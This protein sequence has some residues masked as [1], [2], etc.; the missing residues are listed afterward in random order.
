MDLKTGV[1]N[2][3]PNTLLDYSSHDQFS[4]SLFKYKFYFDFCKRLF[5]LMCGLWLFATWALSVDLSA[6]YNS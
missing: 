6:Q 3:L 5:V 1:W 2:N 4:S